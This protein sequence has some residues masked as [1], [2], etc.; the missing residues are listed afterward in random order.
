M[1]PDSSNS[2]RVAG[3][4]VGARNKILAAEPLISIASGEAARKF[5]NPPPHSPRGFAAYF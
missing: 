4:I 1:L 5:Q 2:A 3:G